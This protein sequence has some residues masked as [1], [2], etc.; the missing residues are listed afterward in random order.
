MAA[1]LAPI[2][3]AVHFFPLAMLLIHDIAAHLCEVSFGCGLIA[4]PRFL[5]HFPH[6]LRQHFVG[7]FMVGAESVFVQF[8]FRHSAVVLWVYVKCR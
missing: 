1:K 2:P 3:V 6:Y 4:F 8:L 7:R 5:G